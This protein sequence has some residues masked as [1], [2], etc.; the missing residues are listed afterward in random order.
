MS[1]P[2]SPPQPGTPVDARLYR[3]A[4]GIPHLRAADPLALAH[5][6]GRNAATDRS[7]QLEV[8]RHRAQGTSAAFLGPDH[9]DWD[10]FARQVRLADTARRCFAALDAPTAAWVRA[11]VDGVNRGLRESAYLAPEF[12]TAGLTPGQ[13]Q[14]WTPLALWLSHHILF[15]GFPGKLWRER[16]ARVL[17]DHAVHLFATDGL[18]ASGSNGWLVAPERTA[19]GAALIAGDPHRFIE[20]PGVYQQIRLA[21]PEYDVVGLAV[22]GVPGIAHFG[23]TGGVAWAITNSM[24][25]YQ[26]LYRERLRRTPDGV[27][28][29]GPD[30]WQ[31]AAAHTETVEV[32]GADP[33]TVEVVETARGPLIAGS[34]DGAG[35]AVS[36]RHPPRVTGRLG[37]EA[38]PVLLRARTVADLDRALDDWAEPVNVVLAADTAGALL[39][40]VAGAVPARDPR[41]LVRP[42]PAREP[43]H[44]WHGLRPLPRAEVRGCAVM[45]NERGLAG[46]LGIEFCAPHRAER[47]AEL[48]AEGDDW[49]T[50]RMAAVHTDTLLPSARPLLD[51][52]AQ[53]P[54]LGA[55][56]AA[57]RDE[58]LGW[59]RRMDADSVTAARYAELRSAVV[60]RYAATPELAALAEPDGLPPVF[61]PWLSATARIGFALEHLL[62]TEL[63]PGIDPAALVRAAVEELA[64]AGPTDGTWGERHRLFAWSALPA[65][66]AGPGPGLSGDHDCVLATSSVPGVTD[67]SARASAARLVWDLADRQRS[68]W[69]VPHGAHGHPRHPHHRDQHRLWLSGALT[70]VVT[71]WNRLTEENSDH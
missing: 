48:L 15:A 29:L 47:I 61:A 3:D 68:A 45:A 41:N 30:G 11:Y 53:L 4:H 39:H 21:C 1:D 2:Q 17:G 46:P 70:P 10:V 33:V 51:L 36:L 9:L 43:G 52:L 7:W 5:A 13:W 57:L 58:L 40:R 69:I 24:A 44:E 62:T 38:L 12:D 64:A 31:P 56:A 20:T 67:V 32:A 6:Q 8:E 26:D 50:D 28:A 49:T 55:R 18:P 65:G 27:E 19:S 25:D 34:P 54:G 59:D 66:P 71:D 22:P 60:R 23:H 37:F 16:V 14:E 42:V 35:D 63:L